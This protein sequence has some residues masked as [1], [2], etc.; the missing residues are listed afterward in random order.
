L[1]NPDTVVLPGGVEALVHFLEEHP[2]V[3]IAGSRL[4]DPSG[5]PQV[6]AFRFAGVASELARGM[7][8]GLLSRLLARW[9]VTPPVRDEPH[10][11]DWVSGA[12]MLVRREVFE[13]GGLLDESYFLY[14]EDVDFCL[15]A[16][17]TGWSCWYVPSSRVVHLSGQSTG[18][19]SDRPNEK[20]QPYYWFESRRRYYLKNFSPLKALGADLALL[21]G[22]ALWRVRRFLQRKPDVDPPQFLSDLF[23]HSVLRRGFRL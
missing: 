19:P 7:R 8:L 12:S 21:I 13:Q 16:H 20:R 23:R 10:P 14:Y 11:T 3:G 6:S 18:F 9:T 15:T 1:L 22:F 4:Q 5:A 17:R 2:A